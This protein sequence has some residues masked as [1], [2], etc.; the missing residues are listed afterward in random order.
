[1]NSGLQTAWGQDK[2]TNAIMLANLIFS[3]FNTAI[4][5]DKIMFKKMWDNFVDAV[6]AKGD[7]PFTG[8]DVAKWKRD[9]AIN[10]VLNKNGVVL[11]EAPVRR[12]RGE[13]DED[14]GGGGGGGGPRRAVPPSAVAT[15]MA[16]LRG[17]PPGA[18]KTLDEINVFFQELEDHLLER[19]GNI[20]A[21]ECGARTLCWRGAGQEFE[22]S[23]TGRIVGQF[24]KGHTYFVI[25]DDGEAEVLRT[26]AISEFQL[27][28]PQVLGIGHWRS[29]GDARTITLTTSPQRMPVIIEALTRLYSAAVANKPIYSVEDGKI[30]SQVR[31]EDE[32]QYVPWAIPEPPSREGEVKNGPLQTWYGQ[33]RRVKEYFDSKMTDHD[34]NAL[35]SLVE[36]GRG[37]DGKPAKVDIRT[38][39]RAD[40]I[41]VHTESNE[42]D[43]LSMTAIEKGGCVGF[44]GGVWSKE[45]PADGRVARR[46]VTVAEDEF[47]YFN[48]EKNV[49]SFIPKYTKAL[50]ADSTYMRANV[51]LVCKK[52]LGVTRGRFLMAIATRAIA[53]YDRLIFEPSFGITPTAAKKKSVRRPRAAAPVAAAR[54]G[55]A[56]AAPAAPARAAAPAAPAAAAPAAR[57]IR[58]T[59]PRRPDEA[60]GS[61]AGGDDDGGED[62]EDGEDSSE[63]GDSEEGDS[64]DSEDSEDGE[65]AAAAAALPD[66]GKGRM[67]EAVARKAAAAE[68]AKAAAEAARKADAVAAE[69]ARKADAAAARKAA[70]AAARKADAAAAAKAPAEE[71]GARRSGRVRKSTLRED[72]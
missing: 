71:V 47:L 19:M 68:A 58:L 55:P 72:A 22:S 61:K 17:G 13:V 45:P 32:F 60:G 20:R 12:P 49:V 62:G 52:A 40:L 43:V 48:Q 26:R 11:A 66:K 18:P 5:S 24:A 42:I 1:M 23:V 2:P 39:Q 69:A 34:G 25:R 56:A 14:G 37:A 28:L 3:N 9:W 51:K 27:S 67:D 7:A 41:L 36:M 31:F 33:T 46:V 44:F 54:A 16:H 10:K 4:L 65:E 70:A 63:E 35:T 15:F 6:K 57:I 8:D 64:E 38:I 30:F 53:V 59:A 29:Y 21:Y 50:E